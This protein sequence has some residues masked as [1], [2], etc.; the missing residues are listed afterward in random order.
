[1]WGGLRTRISK[2]HTPL[3]DPAHFPLHSVF[4]HPLPPSPFCPPHHRR[5]PKS[6]FDLDG[7]GSP[8]SPAGPVGLSLSDHQQQ[9]L[10]Q[11]AGS[12]S[13]AKPPRGGSSH[14][15]GIGGM[16]GLLAAIAALATGLLRLAS[17]GLPLLGSSA[18]GQAPH[19]HHDVAVDVEAQ[20]AAAYPT[21]PPR[22]LPAADK[23][24]SD[25]LLQP[26]GSP[27]PVLRVRLV[28]R[29]LIPGGRSSSTA[30]IPTRGRGRCVAV[31]ALALALAAAL[32]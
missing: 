19:H 26:L 11:R 6:L 27:P 29:A 30:R 1:M 4:G 23:S 20:A 16:P 9:L 12:L 28:A 18:Q 31:L 21:T 15:G 3:P 10:M 22:P 25:G 8:Q 17:A 2:P 13:K 7:I 5:G 24:L 14:G 32:A